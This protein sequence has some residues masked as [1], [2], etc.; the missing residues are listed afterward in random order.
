MSGLPLRTCPP[1]RAWCFRQA[2]IRPLF[3][4]RGGPSE[5]GWFTMG[6]ARVLQF[7]RDEE[8][9]TAVEYAV[10]LALILLVIFSSITAV[11]ITTSGIWNNDST[12]IGA[13]VSGS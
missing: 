13:A 5:W 10:I 12:E 11:G 1:A 2:A 4:H 7:V 3:P 8:G 9:A 6:V